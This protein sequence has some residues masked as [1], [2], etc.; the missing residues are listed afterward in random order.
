MDR[1]AP[2]PRLIAWAGRFAGQRIRGAQAQA[3]PAE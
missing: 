1:N 2:I 3:E